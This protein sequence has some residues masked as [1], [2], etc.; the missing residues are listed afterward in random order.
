MTTKVCSK[1][2]VE[3]DVGEVYKD[4][5][6]KS[7]HMSKCKQCKKHDSKTWR[8]E[9]PDRALATISSLEDRRR[10]HSQWKERFASGSLVDQRHQL[11]LE[12]HKHY[13]EV[14]RAIKAT[15]VSR[16]SDGYVKSVL[17]VTNPPQELIELKRLQLQIHRELKQQG[18]VR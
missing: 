1:C 11:R 17:N 2:K 7:L 16:L 15:Y 5:R 9:N 18:E 14:S 8:V 4:S 6:L 3:K 13:M 12:K 10:K